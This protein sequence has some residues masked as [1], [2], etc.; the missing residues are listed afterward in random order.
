M[1]LEKYFSVLTF[2]E[3]IKLYLLKVLSDDDIRGGH[4]DKLKD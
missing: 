1:V 2:T 4:I 3:Y